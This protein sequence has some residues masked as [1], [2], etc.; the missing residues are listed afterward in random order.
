[1]K[2]RVWKRRHDFSFSSKEIYL[3]SYNTPYSYEGLF[4]R[5]ILKVISDNTIYNSNKI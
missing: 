1:M 4:N 5:G 2:K 3:N